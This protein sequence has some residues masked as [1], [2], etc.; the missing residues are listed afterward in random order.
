MYEITS[1]FEVQRQGERDRY[2]PFENNA[3]RKLLW[4]GSR[5]D[6][7]MGILNQGLLCKPSR[8][9]NSG[10][11]FGDGLYFADMFCKSV[12]YC[13]SAKR[14]A[15]SALLLCE[16]AL[17]KECEM[18]TH[19]PAD[20]QPKEKGHLSVKGRGRLAPNPKNMVY[21]SSGVRITEK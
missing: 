11:M 17:G 14:P 7:Y 13:R 1:L 4:H 3:N 12:N 19:T 15:Y 9:H 8:A 21:D 10:S 18:D 2:E 20:Y 6:N 16:V 5:M